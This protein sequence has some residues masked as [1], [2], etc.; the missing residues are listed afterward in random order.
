MQN[1]NFSIKNE[2]SKT[3]DSRPEKVES[4]GNKNKI[5]ISNVLLEK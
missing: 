5:F 2:K 3:K 1:L 4:L